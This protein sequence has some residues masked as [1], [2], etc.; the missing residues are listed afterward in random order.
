[1]RH[2]STL[3]TVKKW[4]PLPNHGK[5]GKA[6]QMYRRGLKG[7]EKVL[8][9]DNAETQS[10]TK[11]PSNFRDCNGERERGRRGRASGQFSGRRSI[12]SGSDYKTSV[13]IKTL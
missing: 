9:T 5:L 10:F 7:Y 6:E 3:N 13:K 11:Q 4:N 1:L 8:G 2:I 12:T